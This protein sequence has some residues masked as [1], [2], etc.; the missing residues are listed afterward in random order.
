[1][2]RTQIQLTEEQ[3]ARVRRLAAQRGQSF[4]AVIRDAVD[5]LPDDEA[6]RNAR[7]ERALEAARNSTLRS[8]IP[9]LSVEHDR[10][11]AAILAE[12]HGLDPM[13]ASDE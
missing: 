4:A 11:Y 9:D 8:G 10:E 7:F 3:A 5:R 6:E 1:M 12:Q 13:P 2:V